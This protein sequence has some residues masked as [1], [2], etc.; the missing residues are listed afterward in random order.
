MVATIEAVPNAVIL[1]KNIVLRLTEGDDAIIRSRCRNHFDL[2]D[3]VT[4]EDMVEAF[5]QVSDMK[6]DIIEEDDE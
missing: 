4:E 2:N 6:F 3:E 1:W 5:K